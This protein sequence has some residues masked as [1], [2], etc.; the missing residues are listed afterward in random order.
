M[1]T[2]LISDSFNLAKKIQSGLFYESVNSDFHIIRNLHDLQLFTDKIDCDS[3][4]I[5]CFQDKSLIYDVLKL[6]SNSK[7]KLLILD[8]LDGFIVQDEI[9]SR[10]NSVYVMPLNYRLLACDLRRFAY[11]LREILQEK[12]LQYENLLLNLETREL[13]YKNLT[14]YLLNKEFLI[15]QLFM[16]NIDKI[17]TRDRILEMVWDMN[18][19][20]FTNTVEVHVSRLRKKIKN[21]GVS[22]NYIKTVPCSGYLFS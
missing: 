21:L 2:L 10:L 14:V 17:F 8:K 20:I 16:N 22:K 4:I 5:L 1:K 12:Q 11:S 19:D 6:L 7:I 15:L 9:S 18:F 3:L 13:C